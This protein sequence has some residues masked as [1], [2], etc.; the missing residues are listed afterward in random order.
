MAAKK[1]SKAKGKKVERIKFKSEAEEQKFLAHYFKAHDI[2][3]TKEQDKFV[4]HVAAG[5]LAALERNA[6]KNA[7]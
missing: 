6:K 3:G 7:A 1:G 4:Y 5:R 2:K